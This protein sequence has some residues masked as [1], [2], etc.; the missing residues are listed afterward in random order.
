MKAINHISCKLEVR[1]SSHPRASIRAE[2]VEQRQPS[3]R[4]T[5]R[6]LIVLPVA[7]PAILNASQKP[8]LAIDTSAAPAVAPAPAS[9]P[10]PRQIKSYIGRDFFFQYNPQTFK[11]YQDPAELNLA[12][13]KILNLKN[14]FSN[15]SYENLKLN[16][17]LPTG[18]R[19]GD[20]PVKAEVLSLSGNSKITVVQS[21]AAKLKQTFTQVTDI[22]QLGTPQEVVK[23]LLPPTTKVYASSV[24]VYPQ[25]PRDTKS[26]L[27]VIERDPV[28]IYRFEVSLPSGQHAEVAVGALLG[29]I[30]LLGGSAEE[31]KWEEEKDAL[32]AIADTFKLLPK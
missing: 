23:L 18:A 6:N 24:K 11:V 15:A 29:K 8:A 9:V 13:G 10:P 31:S 20:K 32:R 7:I 19:V 17:P 4:D 30:L 22:T 21:Q 27:G 25:P 16:C 1:S 5:L 14:Q 12:P 28:T 26:V 3:R 2:H